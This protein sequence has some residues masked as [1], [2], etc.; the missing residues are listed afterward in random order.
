MFNACIVP[1]CHD[2]DLSDLDQTTGLC[3]GC[4]RSGAP[5]LAAEVQRLTAERDGLLATNAEARAALIGAK[6]PLEVPL[7]GGIKRLASLLGDVEQERDEA[8]RDLGRVTDEIIALRTEVV[9][10]ATQ[11]NDDATLARWQ[12]ADRDFGDWITADVPGE[13]PDVLTMVMAVLFDH[14]NARTYWREHV[15]AGKAER[16]RD[17]ARAEVKRLTALVEEQRPQP[18]GALDEA[19]QERATAGYAFIC[20]QGP[21][22]CSPR[23][24]KTQR[25]AERC[26]GRLNAGLRAIG[27]LDD[28]TRWVAGLL[29]PAAPAAAE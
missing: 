10:W 14:R 18:V 6:L 21:T 16:E 7:V 15:R 25:A 5:A 26:A 3:G 20:L 23:G 12:Q 9:V 1:G 13:P 27:M 17:E 28:T 8:Q 19:A 24:H 22:R 29:N 11:P 2:E 4:A